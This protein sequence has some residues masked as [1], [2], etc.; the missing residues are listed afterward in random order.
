MPMYKLAKV[1]LNNKGNELHSSERRSGDF[2]GNAESQN[3]NS[4]P[5]E[6]NFQSPR[7][8]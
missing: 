1:S 7:F 5:A 4:E 3:E 6:S 2:K 8:V